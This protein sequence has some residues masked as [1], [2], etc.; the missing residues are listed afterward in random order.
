MLAA[1]SAIGPFSTDTYLPSIP[2]IGLEFGVTNIVVQQTLTAYMIPFAVMTLWQGAISDSLG[3]RKVVIAALCVY[4]L[5]SLGCMLSWDVRSLIFFRAMQGFCAGAG[6]VIG[7]AV[8]RDV[9]EGVE[10]R[11]LM[12]RVAVVFAIAPALGP[13]VGG[14]LHVFFGWRSVFAFLLIYGSLML[15]WCWRSF[16]ETLDPEHRQPLHPVSLLRGYAGV[17]RSLPFVMLVLSVTL[18]FSGVFIYIM[19]APVFLM[20]HLGVSETGFFWL[21]GPVTIGMLFGTWLSDRAAA[22][23]SNVR[24]LCLAYTLM[25]SASITNLGFHQFNSPSLPWTVL[26]LV[27]YVMGSSLA[28]PSLTIM[29][30][31]LF[32]RRKGMA[33]SCQSF[34]QSSGN[35]LVTAVIAPFAWSS[36]TKLATVQLAL[37]SAAFGVFVLY[38]I[39]IHREKGVL[40]R[41]D[42]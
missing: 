35:A 21:F 42:S 25:I 16:P 8:V 30:I 34:V 15:V 14:W 7:R 13:V 24:T 1:L 40:N 5:A 29:A 4:L 39:T 2:E 6:M 23:L 37:V 10:A 33:A 32:L 28:M 18:N 27:V 12:A 9:L 26:P 19:S 31:D 3:R 20:E 38:I 22:H 36:V 11:R 17:F 41:R